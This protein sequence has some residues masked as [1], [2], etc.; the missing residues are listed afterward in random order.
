MAIVGAGKM[1]DCRGAGNMGA[2]D[3]VLKM[4]DNRQCRQKACYMIHAISMIIDDALKG[5]TQLL[6]R[7]L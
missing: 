2:T 5:K 6:M 1:S 3:G 7:A 4:H